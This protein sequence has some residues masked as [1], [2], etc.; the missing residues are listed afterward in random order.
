M[1]GMMI[2]TGDR[3]YEIVKLP[4]LLCQKN[5]SKKQQQQVNIIIQILIEK[6][7]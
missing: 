7:M 1:F 2:D 5:P 6:K 4:N 3:S